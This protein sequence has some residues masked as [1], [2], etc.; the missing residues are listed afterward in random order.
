MFRGTFTALVTPFDEKG[1]V[2]YDSLEKLI[3]FNIKNGISGL[4]PCGTTGESPT[5]TDEEHKEVIDFVVKKVKG[6]VPV[7]AGTGSNSTREA[8]E[9]TQYAESVGAN[10]SLQVC[11][12]YNRP[13]QDG[14]FLHFSK[15]AENTCS[16]LIIYNIPPRTGVNLEPETLFRLID[17][18]K[19]IRD[20]GIKEASGGLGQIARIIQQVPPE[21]SVLSGDD[22]IALEVVRIG[23]HGIIS[24]VSNLVQRQ[25]SDMVSSVLQTDYLTAKEFDEILT[26]LYK[27]A[28]L[29]TNPAPIKYMLSLQGGCEEYCRLPLSPLRDETKAEIE[30][31]MR[32]ANLIYKKETFTR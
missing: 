2:D 20:G 25:M 14:L 24:V 6:R 10:A 15:I 3:D 12:Y 22:K 18:H 4:V 17:R 29:E 8:I 7:I 13:T 32:E 30:K 9:M 1:N 31:V 21:F 28:F 27:I 11:P 19:N 5:L 23:G 26:P 16:P